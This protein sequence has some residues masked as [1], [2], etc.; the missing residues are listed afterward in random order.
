MIVRILNEGQFRL[1]EEA[2]ASLNTFDDDVEQA[3]NADDQAAL[4]AVLHA[5]LSDVRSRGERVPDDELADSDLILPDEA[6]TVADVRAWLSDS[7]EGLI[8]D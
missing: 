3:V 5:L 4:T 6:A 8:P 2:L 7:E 1:S